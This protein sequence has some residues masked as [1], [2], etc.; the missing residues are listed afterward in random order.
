MKQ[1]LPDKAFPSYPYK[2][3]DMK[4]ETFNDQLAGTANSSDAAGAEGFILGWNQCKERVLKILDF[5][6]KEEECF[7]K[8]ESKR[9]WT[10]QNELKLVRRK[11]EQEKTE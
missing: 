7:S 4:P 5:E 3:R 9:N 1:A 2:N 8:Q 11:I 6:I 10:W